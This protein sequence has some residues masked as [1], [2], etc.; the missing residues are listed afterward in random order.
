MNSRQLYLKHN[1][2][3]DAIVTDTASQ[4]ATEQFN[5]K[6]ANQSAQFDAV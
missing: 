5:A 2:N 6:S 1:T 4:N 3:A